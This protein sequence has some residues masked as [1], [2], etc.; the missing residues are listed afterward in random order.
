MLEDKEEKILRELLWIRHGHEEL[1]G[2]DGEM[3][4]GRCGIDFKRYSPS[5]IR[6]IWVYK[7]L[8]GAK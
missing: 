7:N 6:A 4:C 2:D 5:T 1:Y 3:Q 8:S